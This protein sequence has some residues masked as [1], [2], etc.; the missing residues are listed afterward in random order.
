MQPS[1]SDFTSPPPPPISPF[2]IF[3]LRLPYYLCKGLTALAFLSACMYHFGWLCVWYDGDLEIQSSVRRLIDD[4][5]IIQSI[6]LPVTTLCC[7]QICIYI[8]M[9]L[10]A[11]ASLKITYFCHNCSF[12]NLRRLR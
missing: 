9:F 7:F 12:I 3:T 5:Y 1:C 4:G 11:K 2:Q 10:E 6:G 8:Y